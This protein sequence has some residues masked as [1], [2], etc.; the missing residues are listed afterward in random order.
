M[1]ARTIFATAIG[2]TL[3]AAA[4]GAAFAAWV[5]TGPGIFMALIESG[6]AWCF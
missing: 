3:F 2:T 6:L 1:S 5:E 4:S